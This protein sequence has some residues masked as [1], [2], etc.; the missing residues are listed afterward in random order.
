MT[1][2]D[3]APMQDNRPAKARKP[4]AGTVSRANYDAALRLL[5]DARDRLVLAEAR[6]RE[7]A[8]GTDA[9]R[10]DYLP[11]ELVRRLLAGEH[12][13]RVWREHRG[14][15]SKDLAAAARVTPSYLSEIERGRKPGSFDAMLR[16]AKALNIGPEHLA[17]DQG[18]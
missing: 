8:M 10:A 17:P 13:V 6:A 4:A 5:E 11:A 2:I 12:P 16:I 14:L 18:G 9:A 15:A 7:D 1:G 3:K